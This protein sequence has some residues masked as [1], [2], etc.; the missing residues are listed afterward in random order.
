MSTINDTKHK[1]TDKEIVTSADSDDTI[2]VNIDGAVKQIAIKDAL[3]VEG[4]IAERVTAVESEVDELNSNLGTKMRKDEPVFAGRMHSTSFT[5]GNS[6]VIHTGEDNKMYVGNGTVELFLEG[7]GK[8]IGL[9]DL[10]TRINALTDQ[11][12]QYY[13]TRMYINSNGGLTIEL[14]DGTSRGVN[15]NKLIE[16]FVTENGDAYQITMIYVTVDGKLEV[17]TKDGSKY[18]IP[19]TKI[20]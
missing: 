8:S 6:Q 11:G 1:L 16:T 7:S 17:W 13:I 18:Q 5:N 4:G 10:S 12:D 3:Q 2:F 14:K 15:I 19:M 9:N 20:R